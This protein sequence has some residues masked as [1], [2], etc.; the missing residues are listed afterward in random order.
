MSALLEYAS[1]ELPRQRW[2]RHPL[3]LAFADAAAILFLLSQLAFMFDMMIT[4]INECNVAPYG[5]GSSYNSYALGNADFVRTYPRV[6][7]W[8]H[9]ARNRWCVLVS[10]PAMIANAFTVTG[11]SWIVAGYLVSRAFS[12]RRYRRVLIV[13]TAVVMLATLPWIW[14]T[15]IVFFD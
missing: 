6:A 11:F 4:N 13:L 15:L 8:I 7:A 3:L 1:P 14:W 5:F 9:G 2:Y 10:Y 12:T